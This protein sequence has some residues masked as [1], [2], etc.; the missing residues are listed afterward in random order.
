MADTATKDVPKVKADEGKFIVAVSQASGL[1]P[2][3]VTSW[4]TQE[5]AYADNGTKGFN[6]LNVKPTSQG[7]SYSGVPI[8]VSKGGFE[9]FRTVEDAIAETANRLNQPFARGILAAGAD[10]KATPKAEIAAIAGTGW[11]AAHYGGTGGSNLVNK[12]ISQW[13]TAS[14]ENPSLPPGKITI[15]PDFTGQ[16]ATVVPAD[17]AAQAKPYTPGTGDG[18]TSALSAFGSAFFGSTG[19]R[20]LEVVGGAALLLLG[21][22]MLAPN[23]NPGGVIA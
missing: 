3:V 21:V 2:R 23:V 10:P 11:D 19:Q 6:F 18:P 17:Q 8:T 20:I 16:S 7:T 12:F 5:G 4:V 15:S 13:G 14:L 22:K 9:Q 1:D